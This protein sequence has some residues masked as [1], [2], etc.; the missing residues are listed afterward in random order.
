MKALFDFIK[1]KI[2]TSVPAIKTVRMW[3]GQLERERTDK[4]ENPIRYPAVFVEIITNETRTFSLGIKNVDLTIRFRFAL[5]SLTFTRLADLDFQE[6]FDFFI[7]SLRGNETDPV[8]FSTLQE[9][10][11]ELDE[12]F[13]SVNEPY[14]DY[15]TIWR[16]KSAYKRGTDIVH[17][18]VTSNVI[19]DQIP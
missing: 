6:N 3:N 19:P 17:T 15:N 14:M 7:Q 4:T 11:N 9:A 13:D 1:A 5:K 2:T 16:K 8:Q 18:P 12:D 10:I